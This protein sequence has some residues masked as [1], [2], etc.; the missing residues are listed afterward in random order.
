MATNQVALFDPKAAVPAFARKAEISALAKSL[1]GGAG[2]KRISIK[3]GVFRLIDGG[4]EIAQVENRYLDVVIVNAAAKIGRTYYEGKYKED[5]VTAPSCWSADG[6]HPDA[7][8]QFPQSTACANCPQNVK[9]S[10]E[11]DSRACR[12]SQRLAVVLANDIEGS[13]MQ[14]QVPAK[15]LFGKE[16]GGNMPLQSYAK[17]LAAQNVNPDMVVTRLKFDTKA[18]SPKLYFKAMR[19]L[20][21]DEYSSVQAQAKTPDAIAAI[22]MTVAQTDHVKEKDE[23]DEPAPPPA[24]VAKAAKPAPQSA[25]ADED[26]DEPPPP[27]VKGKAKAKPAPVATQQEEDE[28]TEPVKRNGKAKAEAAPAPTS[29]KLAGLV[30]AWGE[31]DE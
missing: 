2:G 25:P 28:P 31:D 6:E 16:E 8:V 5:A 18:E 22:T 17:W 20:V 24:K 23:D 19:W 7:S 12:F 26:E 13:V 30:Q 10:G 9:G 1:A 29:A 3:G 27:P 4:Q 14:L 15:S 21:E 11:N